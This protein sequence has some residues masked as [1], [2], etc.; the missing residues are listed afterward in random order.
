M[1]PESK[2]EIL[3]R[4]RE[5]LVRSFDLD[6]DKILPS[7]HLFEELDLD[8]IDAIDLAVGLEEE[9]GLEVEEDELREIRRV[10]DIVSLIHD[11]MRAE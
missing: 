2:D 6:P 3:V 11:K 9:V 1:Q 8:S 4:V 7:S 10:E 5:I